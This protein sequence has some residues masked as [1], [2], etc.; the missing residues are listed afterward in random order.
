MFVSN[1]D[2]AFWRVAKKKLLTFNFLRRSI[3]SKKLFLLTS[4]VLVL[5]LAGSTSAQI[6]DPNHWLACWWS[7]GS[8]DSNL[9]S[10]PNNW[11]A[12]EMYWDEGNDVAAFYKREPNQVPGPNDFVFIGQGVEWYTYPNHMANFGPI[13]SCLIDSSVT[14]NPY[15][16]YI[17]GDA[18]DPNQ[19]NHLE[20]TGG[21]L[22]IRVDSDDW[23]GLLVGGHIE[24]GVGSMSVRGDSIVDVNWLDPADPYGGL[25]DV[26]GGVDWG[27]Y[28]SVGTFTMDDN[29]IV[30]CYHF[31]CPD[32][33]NP[34]DRQE[35]HFNLL[36]GNLYIT[37]DNVEWGTF[38]LGDTGTAQ[39][40]TFDV[41]DGKVTIESSGIEEDGPEQFV[42]L[43]N[44]WID[45]GK[46]T[47]FGNDPNLRAELYVS[48][49]ESAG[50]TTLQAV[51]TEPNQAWNPSPRPGSRVDY[52]PVLSW[53]AG[54]NASG[55]DVYFGTGKTAVE[56]ATTS[57]AEY[58]T[59]LGL[60]TTSYN[61]GLLELDTHY[62]W[63]IDEVNASSVAEWKGLVWDF[64]TADYL[65]VEDFDDY[66][67]N[68]ELYAVWDDYWTNETGSEVFTEAGLVRAGRSMLFT[69]LNTYSIK[70]EEVGSKAD[71]DTTRLGI[72]PNWSASGIEAVVLYFHG[73]VGNSTTVNDKMYL[74]LEDTSSNSGVAI[75]DGDPN[76]VAEASWHEWNID[77]GIFDACGVDLANVDKVHL[78]FG[79]YYE[80][81][82]TADGGSGQVWFDDIRLYPTRCVPAFAATDL[83]D[84]CITGYEDMDILVR[85]WLLSDGE[86]SPSAP[87]VGPVAWYT[88]DDSGTPL[89]AENSGSLSGIDGVLGTG[90]NSPTWVSPGAP[91]GPNPAGALDFGGNDYVTIPDFNGVSVGGFVTNTLTITTWVKRNGD[92]SWWTGM[93]FC[94]R[95]VPD[96]WAESVVHAGLSL[97]DEADWEDPPFSLNE[98][99]YHWDND[100]EGEEVGWMFR[101]GLLVPDGLWTF[102]A[103]A[104]GPT[105]AT[106]YMS[107]GTT[108][109]SATNYHEHVPTRLDDVFYLGRDPRGVW[110]PYP[111]PSHT[112]HLD[113]QLDDVRIYNYTLPVGEIMYLAGVEGT[114]YVPLDSPANLYPKE[115]PVGW[116][117]NNP[118]IVNFM[119]YEVMANDWLVETLWP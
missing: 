7:N 1:E 105:Q 114:V 59:Q 96:D 41:H 50:E 22:T 29:A 53:T 88:L 108:L 48:Y 82:Q 5:C 44:G 110:G 56:N 51:A 23:L 97:G 12:A 93:V 32:T 72:S 54:D 31:D 111:D 103:V 25:L 14:A 89:I 80:T 100:S 116:D 81:G 67:T 26:G 20:M 28:N 102:A 52:R 98:V 117:P 9:W 43:I 62:Y 74:Q 16:L 71:T 113:G 15:S 46:I 99:A 57:S 90:P 21:T 91:N 49:D 60:A 107:D 34:A 6:I 45:E 4:F 18:T 63:R 35:G 65:A 47:A 78:G 112:R 40:S 87:E 83:T 13:G 79:G 104:V 36:G 118:D 69:Y 42:N 94:T 77:L 119:D 61:P 85:D 2:N 11:Y 55:H 37:A 75:Y 86:G 38:W 95:N 115:G 101:T 39:T 19:P 33:F 27:D 109:S 30:K 58:E 8:T 17:G 68:P 73:Q 92:Q 84:D 70:G 10:D 106:V 3:M 66:A 76:D 64:R 24:H